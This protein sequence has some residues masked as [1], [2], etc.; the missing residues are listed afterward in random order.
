MR[1]RSLVPLLLMSALAAL[2]FLPKNESD[3]GWIALHDGESNHGWTTEG[4]VW[5]AASGV[6]SG[7]GNGVLRSKSPFGDFVLRGDVRIGANAQGALIVR[8]NREGAPRETGYAIALDEQAGSIVNQA[9]ATAPLPQGAWTAIE[10][11]ARGGS[12]T[13]KSGGRVVASASGLAPAPGFFALE[14]R[15]GKLEFRNLRVQPLGFR[16]LFNGSSLEGW[17]ATGTPAKPGSKM[18]G[19]L[20]GSKAKTIKREVKAGAIHVSD[21]PGQLESAAPAGDFILQAAVRINGKNTKRAYK[22]LIRGDA[23]KLGTGYAINLQPGAMGALAGLSMA[24][25]P[26]GAAGQWTLLTVVAR[27]RHFQVWADGDCVTDIEDARAD[28][29]N[30]ATD[31]RTTPGA[32]AFYSPDDDADFDIKDVRLSDLPKTFGHPAPGKKA[33]PAAAPAVVAPPP[34]TVSS[35]A[36]GPLPPGGAGNDAAL[37]ALQ[38]QIAEQKAEQAKKDAQGKQEAQLLQQALQTTDPATQ[39]GLFDAIL[40]I[41]P[42]NT[43]AFTGRQEAQKRLE[44][45]NEKQRQENEAKAKA[46]AAEQTKQM[47]LAQAIQGAEAAIIAGN[48]A[49]ARTSLETA[50]RIAPGNNQVRGLR[51]RVDAISNRTTSIVSLAAGGAGALSIGGLAWFWMQRGK[52][53]PFLV[54]T[55]GLDKGK[56]FNID[57]EMVALGAVPEDGGAKN[58]IVL[59]DVERMVSRFHAQIHYKDGKVYVV[60]TKSSNGTFVDKK[61]LAPGKPVELKSGSK[62][63]FG[64]TCEAKIGFEK[65]SQGKKS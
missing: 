14:V 19:G 24:R 65:R 37:K 32:I 16:A 43:V 63:S 20:F 59:R 62:I 6:L 18:L 64:G 35:A 31:A 40:G 36:P 9:R 28:G 13:V 4:G 46:E 11:E 39:I 50:E 3:E 29:P 27:G 12:L 53:D 15:K 60:D 22:L 21:G 33:E 5:N 8:A 55:Q 52:K 26:K 34:V 45:A 38:Q 49:L 57:K 56:K 42:N 1:V 47:N 48:L 17:T 25:H 30:A 23:G 51:E 2:A 61:R 58:D 7:E 41:N 44:A 10:V 54:I